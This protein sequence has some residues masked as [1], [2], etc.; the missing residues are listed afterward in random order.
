VIGMADLLLHTQLEPDQNKFV[1]LIRQSGDAMMTIIDD[2]LDFSEI[3]VGRLSFEVLDFDLIEMI[4]STEK[5]LAQRAQ[6]KGIHLAIAIA[7]EVPARLRADPRRLRQILT[8]LIGNALKF[9]IE[10]KVVVRI[11]K[12]SETAREAKIRFEVEDSGIGI[13]P[14]AQDCLFQ[15]FSQAD[16][17]TTRKYGGMGLGLA[18]AMQLVALMKGEIG[19]H[20]EPGK[21]STFWFTALMEKQPEEPKIPCVSVVTNLTNSLT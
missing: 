14:E 6:A 3:E 8:N 10:G 12:E 15:A 11:S 16:G 13:S 1:R 7:S 18:I 9:T 20:S 5:L 4:E 21:G 2:V 19:V 17:S